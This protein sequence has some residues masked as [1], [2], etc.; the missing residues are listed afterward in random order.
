MLRRGGTSKE[1]ARR[2]CPKSLF[3]EVFSEKARAGVSNSFSSGA[4]ST[5]R[6]PSKGQMLFQLLNS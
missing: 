5:L 2:L 6:L 4:T 1:K 3:K